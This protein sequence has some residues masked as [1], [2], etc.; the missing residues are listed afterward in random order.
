[1]TTLEPIEPL[2]WTDE[3]VLSSGSITVQDQRPISP[4]YLGNKL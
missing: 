4:I 2:E 3:L 1:M